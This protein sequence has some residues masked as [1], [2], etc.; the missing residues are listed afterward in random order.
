LPDSLAPL[1]H[2][3]VILERLLVSTI[4]RGGGASSLGGHEDAVAVLGRKQQHVAMR[5]VIEAS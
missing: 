2:D 4:R 1:G 3:S 5:L